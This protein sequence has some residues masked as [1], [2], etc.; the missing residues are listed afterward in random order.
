ENKKCQVAQGNGEFHLIGW[1]DGRV[2]LACYVSAQALRIDNDA[3]SQA[4]VTPQQHQHERNE[5]LQG[6]A[7]AGSSHTGSQDLQLL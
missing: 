3:V 7:T 5:K 1:R 2:V 6:Q 4:Y